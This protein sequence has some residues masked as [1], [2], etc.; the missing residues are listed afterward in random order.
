MK[1]LLLINLI[2]NIIV[3]LNIFKSSKANFKKKIYVKL[4]YSIKIKIKALFTTN[5]AIFAL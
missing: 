1:W 3:N 5:A 4:E 2:D